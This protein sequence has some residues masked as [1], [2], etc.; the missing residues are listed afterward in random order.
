EF[1]VAEGFVCHKVSASISA[2]AATALATQYSTAYFL[3]HNMGNL[4]KGDRVLI[5]AAAG[6]VGTALV[7]I[8]LSKGCIVF[9]TCSSASKI[10]HLKSAGVQHPINYREQDFYLSVKKILGDK[11]LDVV[12]DPVGGKS[13][14]KGFNLLGAGG[15]LLMY[16]VSSFNQTKTIFGKIRVALQFGIFHPLQFLINSK[17]IIGINMLRVSDNRP[18]KIAEA[19]RSVIQLTEQGVLKPHVGGEY[20]IDQLSEAHAFLESRKSMGKIVVKW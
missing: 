6:G 13:I 16:G 14:K 15:R 5:H 4:M 2:G 3:S 1:A 7:Q 12:F 8:A 18:D 10:E 20:A 19:M 17:G 11:K 9:G